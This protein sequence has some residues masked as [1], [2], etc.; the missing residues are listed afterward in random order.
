MSESSTEVAR[1][2][3]RGPQEPA[4]KNNF[5]TSTSNRNVRDSIFAVLVFLATIFGLVV[6]AV[7]LVDVFVQ[8]VP[9]L[10]LDFLAGQPSSDPEETGI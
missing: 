1:S 5:Q 10:S 7:L 3:G 4:G 2:E 8:G 9:R 6:L